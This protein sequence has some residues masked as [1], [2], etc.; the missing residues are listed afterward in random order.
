[1][2][3]EAA[4]QF[5]GD[6]VLMGDDAGEIGLRLATLFDGTG[7]SLETRESVEFLRITELGA[8]QRI[9]QNGNRLIVGFERHRKRVAVF[10][11]VREREARWVCETCG[12]AVHHF[13]N[14]R[15]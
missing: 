10:A 6:G 8:I 14:Q 12:C 13:S 9:S 1:M 5:P 3:H 2:E 7:K 11:A 4:S 15:Q